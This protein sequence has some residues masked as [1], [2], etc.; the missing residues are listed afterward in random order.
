[1]TPHPSLRNL[2]VPLDERGRV[3]VDEHLRV[4]GQDSVWAIGDCAAVPDPQGG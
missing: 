2:S 3:P 4:E 1:V